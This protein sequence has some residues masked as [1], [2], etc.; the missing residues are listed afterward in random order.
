MAACIARNRCAEPGDLNPLGIEAALGVIK[1]QRIE[2][3]EKRHHLK[4]ALE[5]ARVEASRAARQYDA[6]DPEN[7]IV[8]AELERRWN[9]SAGAKIPH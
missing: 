6:M 5:Q 1:A 4:L 2:H 7:R 8:A 3:V 9:V